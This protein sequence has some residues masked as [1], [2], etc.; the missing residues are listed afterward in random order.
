M[1]DFVKCTIVLTYD[2]YNETLQEQKEK[3]DNLLQMEEKFNVM[4]SQMQ[5]VLSV[6]SS[7]KTQEG[8][9]EIAKELILNGIYKNEK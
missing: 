2:A 5:T 9:Q 8:K 6:L 1:R 4:Q 7:I 3:E